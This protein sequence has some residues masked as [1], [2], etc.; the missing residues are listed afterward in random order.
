MSNKDR[1]K[2]T[3]DNCG[4]IWYS[5]KKI[6]IKYHIWNR[7][8]PQPLIQDP[9]NFDLQENIIKN[10]DG[11]IK[12]VELKV[13]EVKDETEKITYEDFLQHLK[14]DE[15]PKCIIDSKK[16]DLYRKKNKLQEK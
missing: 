9:L 2:Y 8:K 5:R 15:C 13:I 4:S 14:L 3:C 16:A 1:Y 10:S 11:T 6:N 7:K 12:T